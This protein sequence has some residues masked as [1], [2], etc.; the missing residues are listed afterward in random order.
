M[1]T[2]EILHVA[3]ITRAI[4]IIRERRVLLDKDLATI[5]GVETRVLNQAVK[6]NQERFPNDFRFRLTADEADR[7]RS[8]NVILNGKRAQ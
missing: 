1:R 2:A 6:R 7:S 4:L 8:R 3:P 5:Y